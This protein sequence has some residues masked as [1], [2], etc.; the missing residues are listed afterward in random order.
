MMQYRGAKKHFDQI[1]D[2][3]EGI[4]VTLRKV[5]YTKDDNGNIIDTQYQ[6]SSI[7]GSINNYSINYNDQVAGYMNERVIKGFFKY[8]GIIPEIEDKIIDNTLDNPIMYAVT[9]IDS[10]DYDIDEPVAVT[11]TLQEIPYEN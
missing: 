4:T 8:D 11:C 7:V 1:F 3:W 2:I 5:E 9:A 6:D 10:I